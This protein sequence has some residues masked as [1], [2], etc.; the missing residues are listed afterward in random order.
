MKGRFVFAFICISRLFVVQT[1][2]RADDNPSK[3]TLTVRITD[4]TEGG[5]FRATLRQEQGRIIRILEPAR[6]SEVDLFFEAIPL[7]THEIEI[8]HDLDKDEQKDPEEW[9]LEGKD[10]SWALRGPHRRIVLSEKS[11]G[12]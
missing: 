8:H 6:S 9:V 1:P 4:A 11:S 7:G 10:P 3:G 2:V 12:P 5:V